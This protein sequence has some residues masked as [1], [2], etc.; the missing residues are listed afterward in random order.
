[1]GCA[2]ARKAATLCRTAW[3]RLRRHVALRALPG[4]T[5]ANR[6]LQSSGDP[7]RNLLNPALC[8]V[9]C[10][11]HPQVAAQTR[12]APG[13]VVHPVAPHPSSLLAAL[14]WST[15]ASSRRHRATAHP[16]PPCKIS[17]SVSHSFRGFTSHPFPDL[18]WRIVG[19]TRYEYATASLARYV[20]HVHLRLTGAVQS[21]IAS[22]GASASMS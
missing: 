3:I 6:R 4:G 15:P 16:R 22:C 13:P 21:V 8:S 1:M 11:T 5:P 18:L 7:I 2:A 14:R 9:S 20:Q 10:P 17:A 12:R 19:K